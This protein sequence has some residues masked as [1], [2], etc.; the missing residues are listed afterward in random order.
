MVE[1]HPYKVRVPGSSPGGPILNF[2][3]KYG[4]LSKISKQKS[5]GYDQTYDFF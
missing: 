4:F 2:L 5:K 1:H 3:I